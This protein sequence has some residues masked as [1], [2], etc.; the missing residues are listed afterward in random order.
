MSVKA[1]GYK[2]RKEDYGLIGRM[3]DV[4]GQLVSTYDLASYDVD[5]E[6]DD[7]VLVL[8][9]HAKR[10]CKGST[11]QAKIEFPEPVQLD[12]TLGDEP[13]RQEAY[14]KLLKLKEALQAVPDTTDVK[15]NLTEGSLPKLTSGEVRALEETLLKKGVTHWIGVTT[16]GRSVRVSV[17]PERSVADIDI[18]FAELFALRTAMEVLRI[19]EFEVVHSN[20]KGGSL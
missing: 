13:L 20:T 14:E 12:Q 16:D 18:T 6:E 2:L 7:I 15:Q 5:I 1:Y 11:C 17:E 3:G 9:E 19:K 4:L 8:G 10:L